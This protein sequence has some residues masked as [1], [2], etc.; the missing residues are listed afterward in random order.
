MAGLMPG[1][2][3]HR[4]HPYRELLLSHLQYFLPRGGGGGGGGGGG[5]GGGGGFVGAWAGNAGW[6][7]GSEAGAH[8]NSCY[9][10]TSATPGHI[11][12]PS[13]VIR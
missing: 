8:T 3:G 13:W 4:I 2:S 7:R 6:A 12:E 1:G 9:S 10:S 5:A 11:H